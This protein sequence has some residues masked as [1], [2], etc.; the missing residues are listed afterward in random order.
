[1]PEGAVAEFWR[2]GEVIAAWALGLWLMS[3]TLV[4]TLGD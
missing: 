4:W 2:F 1:M 3:R